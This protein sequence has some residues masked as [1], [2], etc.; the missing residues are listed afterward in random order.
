MRNELFDRAVDEILRKDGTYPRGAYALMPPALEF[1]VRR[2][3][4]KE[5]AVRHVTGQELANGFRD[6]MLETY[7][8][9]AWDVLEAYHLKKT[10]DI[11]AL[12]YHLIKVG[13]FGK[14]EKDSIEDFH[15]VY[16]FKMTFYD[17]FVGKALR[18]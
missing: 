2:I 15:E 14:S 6:Y 5:G 10:S 12:V 1:T 13:A 3:R 7:G 8:P 17:P 11:G 4:E 16:D 18:K 9:F